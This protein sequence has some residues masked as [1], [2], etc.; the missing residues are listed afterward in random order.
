MLDTTASLPRSTSPVLI[1]R[2]ESSFTLLG[3]SAILLGSPRECRRTRKNDGS[4]PSD[5]IFPIAPRACLWLPQW[6][7]S[8]SAKRGSTAIGVGG[9]PTLKLPN[10]KGLCGMA[11][12]DQILLQ[13]RRTPLLQIRGYK[14]IKFASRGSSGV[15]LKHSASASMIRVPY[16]CRGTSCRTLR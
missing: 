10:K 11:F 4:R 7:R 14:C 8:V 5:S 13:L 6:K 12:S 9:F 3:C 16:I 15:F 2:N 1:R